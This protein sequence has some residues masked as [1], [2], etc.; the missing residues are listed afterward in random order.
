MH[1]THNDTMQAGE[2]LFFMAIGVVINVFDWSYAD[3]AIIAPLSH[4]LAS[5]SYVVAIIVGAPLAFKVIKGA[6]NNCKSILTDI[7]NKT[8]NGKE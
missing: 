8:R 3:S 4:L 7:K 5:I 1:Y 2:S 6:Y